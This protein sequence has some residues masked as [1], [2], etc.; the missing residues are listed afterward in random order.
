MLKDFAWLLGGNMTRSP[1]EEREETSSVDGNQQPQ[2]QRQTPVPVWS[3]FNSLVH[4]TLPVARIGS[5]PLLAA[6][7]H[8]WNTVLT[9]LM[10]AQSITVK[11]MGPGNKTHF[12]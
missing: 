4:E 11:V 5:P 2:V 10:Q 9:I 1:V 12:T 7:A 8:E 3:G 6:P